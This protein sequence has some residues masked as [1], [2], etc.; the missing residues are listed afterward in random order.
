MS[1]DDFHLKILEIENVGP[2]CSLILFGPRKESDVTET[3]ECRKGNFLVCV[4]KERY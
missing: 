2:W 4:F 3:A 1:N